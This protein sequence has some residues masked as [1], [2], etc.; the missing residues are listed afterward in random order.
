MDQD[1]QTLLEAAKAALFGARFDRGGVYLN[2]RDAIA[3]EEARP[4]ATTDG[5]RRCWEG[6]VEEWR[7]GHDEQKARAQQAEAS[8]AWWKAEG[9]RLSAELALAKNQMTLAIER[10]ERLSGQLRGCEYDLGQTGK[11]RNRA[12]KAETELAKLRA[13]VAK[14][15]SMPAE[16]TTDDLIDKDRVVLTSICN[17]LARTG[18]PLPLKVLDAMPLVV[19]ELLRLRAEVAKPQQS[20]PMDGGKITVMLNRAGVKSWK[21]GFVNMTTPERVEW[22]IVAWRKAEAELARVGKQLA[23]LVELQ[24]NPPIAV[25]QPF[26]GDPQTCAFG[27][28]AFRGNREVAEPAENNDDPVDPVTG[29]TFDTYRRVVEAL[30]GKS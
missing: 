3:R 10:S 30:G 14:S 27:S 29:W 26:E 16:S 28:N 11:L 2:L 17:D 21:G 12:E 25:T 6:L 19:D 23:R 9:E 8:A 18:L 7:K 24:V 22:L 13:H 5:E 20:H 1:K 4:P 15:L